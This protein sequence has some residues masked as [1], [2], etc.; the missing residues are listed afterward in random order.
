MNH[1][2]VYDRF[3]VKQNNLYDM[4]GK[5]LNYCYDYKGNMLV[6]PEY[7]IKDIGVVSMT[8]TQGFDIYNGILFQFRTPSAHNGRDIMNT[9]DIN[10]MNLLNADI[11]IQSGHGN[12]ASFSDEIPNDS[13]FPLLYISEDTTVYTAQDDA[14]VY[15]CKVSETAGELIKTYKFPLA[16]V[17]YYAC[18]C[19]DYQ[20]KV[21]YMLGYK[22][23]AHNNP[24]NNAVIISKWNYENCIENADG[25][26][27][28]TFV[29]SDE[30]S[31]IET[32]QGQTFHDGLMWIT[33]S[34][35]DKTN[36][37]QLESMIYV[38]D[39]STYEVVKTI[40]TGSFLE[41]EGIS[42][43]NDREA[44]LGFQGGI[45]KKLTLTV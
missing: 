24:D 1:M 38:I 44:I 33:S 15:V 6:V 32:M 37:R 13:D 14:R 42:F 34:A 9:V 27:T 36:N 28:P 31:F 45:F 12:S 11:T 40:H 43:L 30:I 2:N 17:G 20:S 16:S 23:R 21:M 10:S 39:P 35:Y 8:A 41:I 22:V 19:F 29:S 5:P 3:G 7:I 26:Y 18:L 4:Y 25:S